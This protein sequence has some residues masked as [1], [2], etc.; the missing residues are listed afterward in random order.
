MENDQRVSDADP[1]LVSPA[2]QSRR[3]SGPLHLPSDVSHLVD[4]PAPLALLVGDVEDREATAS[5]SR[6]GCEQVRTLPSA[7]LDTAF[8]LGELALVL[9]GP[10]TIDCEDGIHLV[11]DLRSSNPSATYLLLG[12]PAELSAPLLVRA[13]RAG[14]SDV[15]D[16]ADAIGLNAAFE[17]CLER[18]R[19]SGERVLAI[20]AHPDDVEIGC[21]GALLDH[22]RCGDQVTVLTLSQGSVGGEQQARVQESVAAAGRIGA[23]LL[24]ADLPDTNIDPGVES[25]RLIEAVVREVDP[26]IVYLHS[27][28]DHHQDHRAVHTAAISATRRVPQVFAYQSPSA[29]NDFAPTRFVPIDA[30]IISKVEVLGLFASQNERSYL[31][32]EMV[33][34]S[35]RYWARTLAPRARYAEPFEVIRSF[36]PTTAPGRARPAHGHTAPVL[37]LQAGSL[38]G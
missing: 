35:A 4:A 12:S 3:S 2:V 28:S 26:T 29:T 23:D 38:S 34:A 7:A 32:P 33:I 19:S 8:G 11:A 16:P 15:V 6:L 21:V 10:E 14:I 24:L 36:T 18:R 27:K 37:Q 17:A 1:A 20:G 31:E 13:L 9:L 22:R 5:L 30:V 25:I